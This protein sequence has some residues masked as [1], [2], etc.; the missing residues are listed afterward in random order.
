MGFRD[1][2]RIFIENLYIF[3][4]YG[5]KKNLL[6]SFRIKVGVCASI[7]A[8]DCQRDWYHSSVYRIVRKDLRLKCLKKRR[9]QKLTAA[10]RDLRLTRE[11]TAASVP[12]IGRRLH[13]LL[14]REDFHRRSAS[15]PSEGPR[16]RARVVKEARCCR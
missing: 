16:L 7:N 13:L 4:G 14:G 3:K 2:D 6:K 11:E 1:D 5:A 8:P 15:Q 12:A 10:N 9:A